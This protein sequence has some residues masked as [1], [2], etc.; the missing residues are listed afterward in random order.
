MIKKNPFYTTV[1][2]A[3]SVLVLGAALAPSITAMSSNTSE[4]N[5]GEYFDDNDLLY[6][7]IREIIQ[8]MNTRKNSSFEDCGCHEE[9]KTENWRFPCLCAFLVP[10]LFVSML[11]EITF[12]VVIII[13][14]G[15]ALNCFWI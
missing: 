6:Q 7:N 3:L 14:V 13:A 4:R 8:E 12:L 10:I 2:Y 15:Y 11:F 5:S 1:M 9:S